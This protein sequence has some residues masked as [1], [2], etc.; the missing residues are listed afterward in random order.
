MVYVST[1][2]PSVKL[3][4]FGSSCSKKLLPMA[5]TDLY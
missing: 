5:K 3:L 4:K 1:G 2:C